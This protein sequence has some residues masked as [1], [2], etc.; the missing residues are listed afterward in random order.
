MIVRSIYFNEGLLL[1]PANVL[2]DSTVNSENSAIDKTPKSSNFE[3][4]LF[5][6]KYIII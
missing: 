5:Y 3:Y 4:T 1:L 2:G 6:Y